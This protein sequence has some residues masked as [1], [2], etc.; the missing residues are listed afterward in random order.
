M[1][2]KE[3][4]EPMLPENRL[5]LAHALGS[6]FYIPFLVFLSSHSFGFGTLSDLFFGIFL[7][8]FSPIFA[9]ISVFIWTMGLRNAPLNDPDVKVLGLSI[10]AYF[11]GAQIG[12]F[13]TRNK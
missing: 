9:P 10:L 1:T 8:L 13:I 4:K 7:F 12:L 6:Y 5:A 11:L 3:K 2:K